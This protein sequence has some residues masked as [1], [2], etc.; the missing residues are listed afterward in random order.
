MPPGTGTG[1]GT[2]TNGA[3]PLQTQQ[4]GMGMTQQ[5]GQP[6]LSAQQQLLAGM[7]PAKAQAIM[8]VRFA[9]PEL[10][11]CS[12]FERSGFCLRLAFP[13]TASSSAQSSRSYR[14]H[15]AGFAQ[16]DHDFEDVFPDQVSFFCFFLFFSRHPRPEK[17]R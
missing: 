8:Q 6:L 2:T 10:D 16:L 4:N 17:E 15:V 11:S 13:T 5:P 7:T 1:A 3:V 9:A 12:S 14:G